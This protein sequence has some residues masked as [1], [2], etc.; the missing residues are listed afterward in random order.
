MV[1]VFA[2]HREEDNEIYLSILC[3]WGNQHEISTI[4]CSV[5]CAF[6]GKVALARWIQGFRT[7]WSAGGKFQLHTLKLQHLT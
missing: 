7:K 3:T 1:R 2:K 4:Y 6:C 5:H